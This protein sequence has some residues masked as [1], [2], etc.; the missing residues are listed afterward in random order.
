MPKTIAILYICTGSYRVFWP[1]FYENFRQNFLPEL[2][3]T[4][5]VFTDVAQVAGEDNPDVRRIPQ[6]ALPWPYSTLQRFDAFLSQE[7]ALAGYDYLFFANANLFCTGPVHAEEILPDAGRSLTAV[8]HLP[9]DGRNPLFH[10]YERRPACWA[11]I[12]YNGG[13][14][15]V[16]GGLN[17]GTA[18]AYLALCRELQARTREDLDRGIIARFHDE[19][20]LNRLVAEW[21]RRFRVLPPC[22]CV[23]EETPLPD[24][25]DRIRV[26]QKSRFLDVEAVKGAPK[27]Q[28]FFERKWEAFTLNWLPYLW[29][30]RDTLLR[31]RV[32]PRA[33]TSGWQTGNYPGGEG[34]G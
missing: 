17:G 19:S 34:D 12:P 9:Y 22:F 10:P 13:T 29:R 11:G 15:Y 31:R 7:A 4:F 18:A 5:F 30:A 27:P 2:D 6:K 20:Q 16:A 23:P 25:G 21:P 1:G 32:T 24:G 8:C 14:Y 3:K 26:L 33:A 28:N